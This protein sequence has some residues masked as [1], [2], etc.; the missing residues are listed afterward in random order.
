MRLSDTL[1]TPALCSAQVAI[2]KCIRVSD[3]LHTPAFCSTHVTTA[4]D[5]CFVCRVSTTVEYMRLSDTLRTPA[6][7]S[8]HVAIAEYIRLSGTL[9][10]PA[11]CSVHIATAINGCLVCKVFKYSKIHST[12]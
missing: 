7:C 4:T 3:T 9:Y 10:T 2:T 1:N 5:G 12:F 6:L 8:A 11:F